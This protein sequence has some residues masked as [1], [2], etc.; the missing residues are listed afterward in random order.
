M[1]VNRKLCHPKTCMMQG[2]ESVE[3]S[4]LPI[5]EGVPVEAARGGVHMLECMQRKRLLVAQKK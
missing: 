1:A 5:D 4:S 3:G 2:C